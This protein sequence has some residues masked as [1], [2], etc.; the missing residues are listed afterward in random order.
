ML[1][2]FVLGRVRF[3]RGLE[4]ARALLLLTS[5]LWIGNRPDLLHL[6]FLALDDYRKQTGDLPALHDTAAADKIVELAQA[7]KAKT[8]SEAD[9]DEVRR[10]RVEIAGLSGKQNGRPRSYVSQLSF[11]CETL[12]I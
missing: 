2:Y 9:I 1:L 4:P 5:S 11:V 8:S 7:A 6:V 12:R 10:G 3:L